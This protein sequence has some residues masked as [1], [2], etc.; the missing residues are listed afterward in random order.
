M[1]FARRSLRAHRLYL[2]IDP[3]SPEGHE[4]RARLAAAD[5]HYREG[6]ARLARGDESGDEEIEIGKTIAPIDPDLYLPLARA[7]WDLERDDAAA[8]AYLK[9]ITLRPEARDVEQ[10]RDEADRIDQSIY[11]QARRE[12][13]EIDREPEPVESYSAVYALFFGIACGLL[14]AVAGFGVAYWFAR[15][16]IS[17]ERLATE[18][19]ELHPAIAYLI[20]SMR[21]ELLKHRIGAASDAV[22]ALASGRPSDAQMSFLRTRLFGGEPLELAFAGHVRAF[23]RALGDRLGLRAD[24]RFRRAARAIAR[25]SRIETALQKGDRRAIRALSLAHAELRQFDRELGQLATRLVRTVVDEPFIRSVL[26]DVRAEHSTGLV[27]LDEVRVTAPR[28]SVAVEVFR[29]DLVLVLKNVVRNAILAMGRASPSEARRLAVDVGTDVLPTGEEIVRVRVLD[30]SAESLSTDA[31][32][33]RRAD[34][35]LGLVTAALS[36]YDGSIAVEPG[37]DGYA[38]SVTV[39]FFRAMTGDDTDSS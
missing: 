5:R 33:D 14:L 34:R 8:F 23:E 28:A 18:R 6:I 1:A 26:D 30:T 13:S 25:L 17:L 24:P 21:H 36:R 19:P 12:I 32:Y 37:D 38:K 22:A 29:F 7:L 31:I 3:S 39:R 35:G 27:Q 10:A 11:Q 9:Y 16:G 4:A 2:E 20:G 15:R